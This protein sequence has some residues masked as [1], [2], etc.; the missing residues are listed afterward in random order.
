MKTQPSS[1]R[2]GL[3]QP[4]MTLGDEVEVRFTISGR[5]V[6]RTFGDQACVDIVSPDGR[7]W[8]NV[9]ADWVAPT[10]AVLPLPNRVRDAA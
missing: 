10:A 2:H 8:R 5:V 4:V 6:A 3:R 7:I 9:P 1:R